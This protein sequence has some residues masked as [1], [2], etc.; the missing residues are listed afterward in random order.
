MFLTLSLGFLC[1]ESGAI[2]WILQSW[3]V[4]LASLLFFVAACVM[5]VFQTDVRKRTPQN[6][7]LMCCFVVGFALF[8]TNLLNEWDHLSWM[9]LT[10]ALA[11]GSLSVF[12]GSMLT[13]TT[14]ELDRM[15]KISS[16]VGI[17]CLSVALPLGLALFYGKDYSM[18]WVVVTDLLSLVISYYVYYDIVVFHDPKLFE[19]DDYILS[20]LY[21]YVD[22]LW[23]LYNH[24]FKPCVEKC[25]DTYQREHY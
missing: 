12:V 15:L 1:Y 17:G 13:Q 2:Q 21:V 8:M 14:P 3:I 9:L 25:I 10:S 24:V 6:L 4:E 7:Q 18:S 20:A 23:M 11:C 19:E 16:L 5:L 22:F